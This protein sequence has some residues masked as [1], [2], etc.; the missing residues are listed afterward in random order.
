MKARGGAKNFEMR[1]T[2]DD[3]SPLE[4]KLCRTFAARV[5]ERC[6]PHVQELRV[7][8]SRARGGSHRNSDLDVWVLLDEAPRERCDELTDLAT[9]LTLE[10]GLPF[11]VAPLIMAQEH[12]QHLRD[13]ERLIVTELE[14]DGIPL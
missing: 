1:R 3:L 10:C 5:R 8:G 14:R 7:F 6:G 13:R 12:Y 9:D 4:Q 2:L 11:A